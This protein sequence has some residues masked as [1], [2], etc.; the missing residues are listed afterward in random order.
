MDSKWIGYGSVGEGEMN[1]ELRDRCNVWGEVVDG[2]EGGIEIVVVDG[3]EH[4]DGNS[5]YC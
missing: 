1:G 5:E 3:S 2:E 4:E